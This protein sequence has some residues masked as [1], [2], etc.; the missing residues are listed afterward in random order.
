MHYEAFR[1]MDLPCLD[2]Y[3]D[4]SKRLIGIE[5]MMLGMYDLGSDF[6]GSGS[7]PIHSPSQSWVTLK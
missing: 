3:S 5:Q 7:S 6:R 2:A 4:G 1:D